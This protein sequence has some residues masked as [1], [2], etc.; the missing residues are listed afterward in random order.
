[1]KT[2]MEQTQSAFKSVKY[3]IKLFLQREGIFDCGVNLITMENFS[4]ADSSMT[5]LIYLA[6][7]GLLIGKA[8]KTIDKLKAEFEED[9]NM[10]VVINLKEFDPFQ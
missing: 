7:P 6:R 10:E 3:H 5:I 8:G 4:L 9:F 1:M 2:K